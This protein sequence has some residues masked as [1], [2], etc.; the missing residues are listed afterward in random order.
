MSQAFIR[1]PNKDSRDCCHCVCRAPSLW[2]DKE[3]R[4]K[5][6]AGW[7]AIAIGENLPRPSWTSAAGFWPGPSAANA[8]AAV[9]QQE[10][11]GV[12][13]DPKPPFQLDPEDARIPWGEKV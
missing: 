8:D 7:R 12:R 6:G 11:V 4:E 10:V 2:P 9:I 13:A 1:I 5:G 3:A